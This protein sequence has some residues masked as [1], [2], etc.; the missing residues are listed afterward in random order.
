MLGDV[1]GQMG[2]VLGMGMGQP[3]ELV[4][5]QQ[6]AYGAGLS[7]SFSY[8]PITS[9]SCDA[10]YIND[11]EAARAGI[12]VGNIEVEEPPDE[13]TQLSNHKFHELLDRFKEAK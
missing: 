6:R 13:F 8:I 2:N 7:S 12:S 4:D 1:L 10:F 5:Y 3:G 11:V 9:G